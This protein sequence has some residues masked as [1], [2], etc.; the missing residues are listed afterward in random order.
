MSGLLLGLSPARS[1]RIT[2]DWQGGLLR[3]AA[4]ITGQAI[5][6]GFE[7]MVQGDPRAQSS[8]NTQPWHLIAITDKAV[9]KDLSECGEWASHLSGAALGVAIIHPD[10]ARISRSCSILARRRLMYHN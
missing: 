8:K 7:Q 6:K 10:P 1:T 3:L 5:D 4:D 2:R 9:L